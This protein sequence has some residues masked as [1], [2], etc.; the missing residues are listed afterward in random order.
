MSTYREAAAPGSS[1]GTR[2]S[3]QEVS[4]RMS[5][6]RLKPLAGSAGIKGFSFL[7]NF[8][9]A[10]APEAGAGLGRAGA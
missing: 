4:R 3:P 9:P 1:S 6:T 7:W 8:A 2:G 10:P 5:T